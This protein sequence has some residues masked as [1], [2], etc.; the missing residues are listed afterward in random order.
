MELKGNKENPSV[1]V[2]GVFHGDEPQ[3]EYLINEYLKNNANT[4]RGID[5]KIKM[6]KV[7]CCNYVDK[8]RRLARNSK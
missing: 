7:S 4:K 3:G 8:G 5:C 2:I 1:L 6:T